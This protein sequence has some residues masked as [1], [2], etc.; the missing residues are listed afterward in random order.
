M[1]TPP[2]VEELDH[3]LCQ[4]DREPIEVIREK[5]DRFSELGLS[6]NDNRSRAEWIQIMVDNPI[7]IERPIVVYDDKAII[8][9]PPEKIYDF[10]LYIEVKFR[11]GS[12]ARIEKVHKMNWKHLAHKNVIFMYI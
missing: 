1:R 5:E 11:C 2:T 4:L 8:A 12:N 3:I 7:L 9:R 10:Y 6:I